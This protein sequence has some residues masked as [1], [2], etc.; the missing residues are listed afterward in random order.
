LQQSYPYT[1]SPIPS[2]L[3][4]RTSALQ[5]GIPKSHAMGREKFID[6]LILGQKR[7]GGDFF[8]ALSG[9]TEKA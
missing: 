5:Y 2:D 4:S 1:G 3:P 6:K 8:A 9:L 7:E